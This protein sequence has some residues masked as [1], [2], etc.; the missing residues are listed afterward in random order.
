[1]I[2]F[3]RWVGFPWA[4]M[5]SRQRHL[6]A[7]PASI[8]ASLEPTVDA[9]TPCSGA[10]K[11]REMM[12]MH[13]CSISA[14]CGYSSLSIKFLEKHSA[15]NFS[16]CGF[17][18][19]VRKVAKFSRAMP[20][21]SSSSCNEW[22]HRIRIHP[23][24]GELVFRN[25]LGQCALGVPRCE[26]GLLRTELVYLYQLAHYRPPFARSLSRRFSH[27]SCRR[28]ARSPIEEFRDQWIASR[29]EAA[30]QQ[31]KCDLGRIAD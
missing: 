5:R 4:R 10:L 9:P 8:T 19:V 18:Q 23:P 26:L 27:E 7:M 14:V 17:I 21:R 3:G 24:I 1:M 6:N 31:G 12:L 20:S 16:A 29:L 28:S 25:G 2:R 11:S 13:R 22:V 30:N 15:N